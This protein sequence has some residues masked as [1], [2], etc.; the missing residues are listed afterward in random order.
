MTVKRLALAAAVL[1]LAVS[2]SASLSART[3]LTKLE[4]LTFS[5]P[6]ALPG[7]T[8]PAGTY[9]FE[10][11]TN[12]IV[13]RVLNRDRTRLY[14]MGLTRPIIRDRR[15]TNP[16][17]LFGEA[18]EGEPIPVQAWFPDRSVNGHGFIY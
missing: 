12:P 7:M 13:V 16:H 8:L 4:Y 17:V 9:T 5:K 2:A 18:K 1:G 3:T 11:D 10:E 15:D 14:Y 6:I